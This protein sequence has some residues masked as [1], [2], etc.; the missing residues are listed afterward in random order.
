ML[1][2]ERKSAMMTNS[3]IY[4]I[5]QGHLNIWDT[6][7]RK[8]LYK[9][10]EDLGLNEANLESQAR[11]TLGA[12]F[13][14]L[15][16]QMFLG[17]DV[18][19]LASGDLGKWLDMY[20]RQPPTMIDGD[21]LCEH[22]RTL[23]VAFPPTKDRDQQLDITDDQDLQQAYFVLTAIYDLLI[24][25]DGAAQIL[26]WK[27]HQRPLTKKVLTQNWQTRLYLYIL[28]KTTSYQPAQISMTY[29]FA[30]TG[31]SVIIPYSQRDYER[32]E[33]DLQGILRAI[34]TEQDYPQLP[35]HSQQCNFCEFQ[36]RCDRQAINPTAAQTFT[37]NLEDIPEVKI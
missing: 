24:W 15:M 13:H 11:L 4:A 16:Q 29:W 17:L 20:D 18:S 14:L 8:Y 23:E 22:C 37:I 35:V 3:R 36:E 7:R 30:N 21:R 27:T 33:Q 9:Y 32:T 2:Q 12:N 28:A 19:P 6:C 26:D 34:A 31:T 5:S 25:G 1:L 10:L